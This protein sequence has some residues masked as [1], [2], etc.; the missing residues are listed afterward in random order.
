VCPKDPDD[1]SYTFWIIT[2]VRMQAGSTN[3]TW[4]DGGLISLRRY[5][6]ESQCRAGINKMERDLAA[7]ADANVSEQPRNTTAEMIRPHPNLAKASDFQGAQ[8]LT[9]IESSTA[10]DE[11]PSSQSGRPATPASRWAGGEPHIHDYADASSLA[12][13]LPLPYGRV[14]TSR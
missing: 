13:L 11:G 2:Q 4:R 5:S 14:I 7:T 3:E 6:S 1:H 12:Q 10:S 9:R 8:S